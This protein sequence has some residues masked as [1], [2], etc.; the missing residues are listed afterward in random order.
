MLVFIPNKG[1]SSV[2]FNKEEEAYSLSPH[3]LV[4][5]TLP[6]VRVYTL[7][8]LGLMWSPA[9]KPHFMSTVKPPPWL[10]TVTRATS[11]LSSNLLWKTTAVV[12]LSCCL[13]SFCSLFATNF[14]LSLAVLA[15][16][17][18]IL[19]ISLKFEVMQGEYPNLPK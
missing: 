9:S 1:K 8:L 12:L 16:F 10:L 11:L 18:R 13:V 15:A 14:Q 17:P 6:L 5:S 4:T 7:M 3:N 2:L 19:L